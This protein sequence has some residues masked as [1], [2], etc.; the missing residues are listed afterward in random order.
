MVKKERERERILSEK[1]WESLIFIE[2]L[3]TWTLELAR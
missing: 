2:R 1:G 3:V